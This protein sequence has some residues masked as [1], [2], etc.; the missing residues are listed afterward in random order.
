MVSRILL[1]GLSL[2]ILLSSLTCPTFACMPVSGKERAI[3]AEVK[4]Y[5]NSI[6]RGQ[7]AYFLENQHFASSLEELD[8]KKTTNFYQYEI[9]VKNNQAYAI[10]HYI[11][12]DTPCV[13][14][15]NLGI[16]TVSLFGILWWLFDYCG[17]HSTICFHKKEHCAY[18]VVGMVYQ[19][20][21]PSDYNTDLISCQSQ[22]KKRPT[23]D[24][25]NGKYLCG[26]GSQLMF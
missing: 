12:Q 19:K 4:T 21:N 16:S 23:I 18:S 7:Q 11:G 26:E 13:A 2:L 6:N 20:E 17:Y 25:K 14:E 5:I 8:L 10:A 15:C 1:F 24:Y 22:T 3:Q 9:E